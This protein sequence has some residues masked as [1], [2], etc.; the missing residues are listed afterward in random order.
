MK[1]TLN[2]TEIKVY[3]F[4]NGDGKFKAFAHVVLNDMLRLSGLRIVNGE[5]G[6]FVSYPSEKGKDGQYYSIVHPVNRETRNTIQDAVL[7]TYEKAV[8]AA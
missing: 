3:P 1:T 6:L 8:A 5:N 4:K 7:A 2:V